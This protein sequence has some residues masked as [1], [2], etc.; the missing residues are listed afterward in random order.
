M[1]WEDFSLIHCF[2]F[3]LEWTWVLYLYK[4]T[5]WGLYFHRQVESQEICHL[6]QQL[7]STSS[8]WKWS[9]LLF[10]YMNKNWLSLNY[11]IKE[12]E[13]NSW[14]TTQGQQNQ[15]RATKSMP[16]SN[17]PS[18]PEFWNHKDHSWRVI[19]LTS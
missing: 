13:Y 3:T 8:S 14:Y 7:Q 4:D 16:L 5:T 12:S 19:P 17:C 2:K 9:E 1:C 10:L 11:S 15:K 6:M 18:F